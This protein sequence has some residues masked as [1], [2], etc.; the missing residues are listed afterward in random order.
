MQARSIAGLL[1][2]VIIASTE[3]VAQ[4][5]KDANTYLLHKITPQI[6]A[7]L[8]EIPIGIRRVS[9]YRLNYDPQFFTPEDANYIRAEVEATIQRG[10]AIRIL[11]PPELEPNDELKIFGND[12]TLQVSNL[13]GR[14]F[15]DNSQILLQEVVERYDIQGL[16]ELTIQKKYFEGI[17]LTM[18]MINPNNQ[19]LIFARSFVSNPIRFTEK[20]DS[21]IHH[22]VASFGLGNW[23]GESFLEIQDSGM[24][25]DTVSVNND[26][27]ILDLNFSLSYRQSI[28]DD[29]SSYLGALIGF[30]NLRS[31]NID[32]FDVNF[33]ELGL[34]WDQAISKRIAH[35]NEYRV[36]LLAKGSVLFPL[37]D[38]SGELIMISPGLQLNLTRNLSLNLYTQS[39]LSGERIREDD[40]FQVITFNR[41]GY[42]LQGMVRF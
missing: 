33:F 18:R 15:A 39:I 37:G 9:V 32:A 31:R 41:F 20:K 26:D 40:S 6:E 23:N 12:S 10:S 5:K 22:F 14:S 7:A 17:V 34:T 19:E 13:E 8:G 42:G 21:S 30:H 28:S 11:T 1:L 35:I 16:V 27:T 3:V 2:M 36:K 4:E 38:R 29:N 24:G 25:P